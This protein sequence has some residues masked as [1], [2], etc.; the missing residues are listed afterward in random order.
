V[1]SRLATVLILMSL[2]LNSYRDSKL[3]HVPYLTLLH[4]YSIKLSDFQYIDEDDP[5][6]SDPHPKS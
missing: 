2:I 4:I 5:K 1:G 3:I 6:L